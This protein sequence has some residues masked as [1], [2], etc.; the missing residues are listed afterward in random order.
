MVHLSRSIILYHTLLRQFRKFSI[1]GEQ[2]KFR[3]NGVQE[4]EYMRVQVKQN[5]NKASER[6][7][8]VMYLMYA[9]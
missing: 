9:C 8:Q 2:I 5:R 1:K 6:G 4:S 7:K 3:V